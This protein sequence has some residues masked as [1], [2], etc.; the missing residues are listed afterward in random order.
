L[1][2]LISSVGMQRMEDSVQRLATAIAGSAILASLSL[3]AFATDGGSAG[4][5]YAVSESQSG[6]GVTIFRGGQKPATVDFGP[7]SEADREQAGRV[8]NDASIG[9]AA[10]AFSYAAVRS[11]QENGLSR[12]ERRQS[13]TDVQ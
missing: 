6:S 9:A 10:G 2:P 13:R 8:P 12:V 3:P 7:G 4:S 5:Q 11:T 1:G